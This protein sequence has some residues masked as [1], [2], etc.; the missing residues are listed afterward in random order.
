[1]AEILSLPKSF[2]SLG[3][4][5]DLLCMCNYC[6]EHTKYL[7]GIWYVQFLHTQPIAQTVGEFVEKYLTQ[8]RSI[9]DLGSPALSLEAFPA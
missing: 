1:M 6:S 8:V 7:N 2:F 4:L 5:R 3:A 9:Q